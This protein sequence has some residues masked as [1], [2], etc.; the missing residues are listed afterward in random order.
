MT[1]GRARTLFPSRLSLVESI[2]LEN[3][4]EKSNLR[5]IGVWRRKASVGTE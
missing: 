4:D 5:R 1:H 2:V 3:G